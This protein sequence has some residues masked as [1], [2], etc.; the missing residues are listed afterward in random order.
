MHDGARARAAQRCDTTHNHVCSLVASR[1]CPF[2]GLRGAVG[3]QLRQS[4][5]GPKG[6][7]GACAQ[8]VLLHRFGRLVLVNT[9]PSPPIQFAIQLRLAV[10]GVCA[11]ACRQRTDTDLRPSRPSTPTCAVNTDQGRRGLRPRRTSSCPRQALRRTF[12]L[13]LRSLHDGVRR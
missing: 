9:P 13:L 12:V 6:G 3:L 7:G 8:G 1:G 10:A 4:V 5:V 11:C 2:S